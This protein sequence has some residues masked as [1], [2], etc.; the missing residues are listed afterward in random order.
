[1]LSEAT[2]WR[3][4]RALREHEHTHVDRLPET[5]DV[6]FARER[7]AVL[8][9]A[10]AL[11]GDRGVAEDIVQ[12][13]FLEAFWKWD[14][15]AMYDRPGA[16]VRRVVANMSVSSFRRRRGELRMLT[17]LMS[18]QDRVVPELSPSTLAFWLAVRALPKRQA[19]VAALFYLEDRPIAEIASI[20]EMGGGHRE[21]ASV[22]RAE[23]ARANTRSRRGDR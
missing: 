1:M 8:G 20:L 19:Q 6:F 16:W 15:I 7:D 9:L 10:F 14:R 17:Q 22:R 12:D 11:T 5:F 18:R 23:D 2:P 21:E 13:A 4:E 3:E